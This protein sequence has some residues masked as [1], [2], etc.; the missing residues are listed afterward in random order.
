M[1]PIWT[2]HSFGVNLTSDLTTTLAARP[3]NGKGTYFVG[4]SRKSHIH[5][6][7]C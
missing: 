4:D 5:R 3:H 6:I 2:D 7:F 1:V